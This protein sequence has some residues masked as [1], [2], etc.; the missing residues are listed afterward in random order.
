MDKN[1]APAIKAPVPKFLTSDLN[2]YFI[3]TE[4]RF[5]FNFNKK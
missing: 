2:N 4:G 1:E 5:L 3:V